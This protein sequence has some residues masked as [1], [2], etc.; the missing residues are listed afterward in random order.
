MRV[1]IQRVKSSLVEVDGKIISRI[2]LGMNL[3]VGIAST[4]TEAEIN[5]MCQKCLNLRLFPEV[6]GGDRL[7]KSVVEIAGEILVVSQFTLYANCKKGL[8]PSFSR[9]AEP[10]IAKSLYE[11]FVSGLKQSGLN[12]ETGQFGA[13]MQVSIFNDGPVTLLLEKEAETSAAI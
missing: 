2:G 10:D 7:E 5:W 4:D 11:Q 9:A 8:S 3:L 12:I 13:I 1:L 6:S